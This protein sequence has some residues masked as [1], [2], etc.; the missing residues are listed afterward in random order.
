[1]RT[2]QNSAAEFELSEKQVSMLMGSATSF[3]NQV[4]LELLYSCGLR[5]FEA[6]SLDIPDIDFSN[7]WLAIRNGKGSK[8]RIV[9]FSDD[10]AND[11]RALIGRRRTGPVFVSLRGERLST[12]SVSHIVEQAGRIAGL[13]NPNPRRANIKEQ[14]LVLLVQYVSI[15]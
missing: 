3:R 6:C 15:A 9:P 5:R 2:A 13:R 4:V 10:L 1:M 7:I 12:R 14:D 11:L 8:S